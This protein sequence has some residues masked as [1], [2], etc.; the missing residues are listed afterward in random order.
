MHLKKPLEQRFCSS[1]GGSPGKGL[2]IWGA[3]LQGRNEVGGWTYPLIELIGLLK[4]YKLG[5]LQLRSRLP[6]PTAGMHG[7]PRL[8]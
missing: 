1:R 5:V 4:L 7:F 6:P 8:A 3:I 2:P